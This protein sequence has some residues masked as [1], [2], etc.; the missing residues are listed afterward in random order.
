MEQ[1]S[2]GNILTIVTIAIGFVIQYIAIV[3]K[4]TE[5]ITKLEVKYDTLKE[6]FD[7]S[8]NKFSK[9]IKDICATTHSMIQNCEHTRGKI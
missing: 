1:V 8:N 5:R 7:T 2:I 4:F 9:D 6:S 3:T